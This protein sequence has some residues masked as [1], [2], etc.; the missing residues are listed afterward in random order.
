MAE[1]V[2]HE[3]LDMATQNLAEALDVHRPRRQ[4]NERI[5][6]ACGQIGIVEAMLRREY[7]LSQPKQLRL[8]AE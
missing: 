1:F 6:A 8:E 7:E 3:L 5:L 2:L 4:R